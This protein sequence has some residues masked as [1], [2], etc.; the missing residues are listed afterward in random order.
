M[1]LVYDMIM[2]TLVFRL[3]GIHFEVFR[4]I[5]AIYVAPVVEQFGVEKSTKNYVGVWD[6]RN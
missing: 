6:P 3:L 1:S 4:S 2:R 5:G